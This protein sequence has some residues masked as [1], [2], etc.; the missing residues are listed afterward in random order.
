MYI[1]IDWKSKLEY[2]D[3]RV[4]AIFIAAVLRKWEYMNEWMG[5]IIGRNG[6]LGN[7]E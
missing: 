3:G 1:H 6:L 7:Y 5:P 4:S 2:Q